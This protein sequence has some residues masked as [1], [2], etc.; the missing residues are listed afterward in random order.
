MQKII[1]ILIA[2]KNVEAEYLI[3]GL[4]AILFYNP[5]RYPAKIKVDII[6]YNILIKYII[7]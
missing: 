1:N 5:T 2:S 7:A 3:I 4:K 6:T